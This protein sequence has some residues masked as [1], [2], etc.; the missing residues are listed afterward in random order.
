[1]INMMKYLNS[2]KYELT[3]MLIPSQ[4]KYYNH[5]MKLSKKYININ[6][7]NPVNL[8]EITETINKFDIGIYILKPN[9]YNEKYAL[10]NKFFEFLQARLAIAIGPSIEMVKII[11]QYNLGIYSK[12]FTSKS[13]ANSINNLTFERIMEYKSNANTF[14]QELSSTVN[15][16]KIKNIIDEL[17]KA[18]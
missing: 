6:F 18:G 4:L 9:N 2:E 16:N 10:P 3:F 12:K 7:I 8:N 1:M 17:L 13:L 5:L 11:N 15:I 14:A